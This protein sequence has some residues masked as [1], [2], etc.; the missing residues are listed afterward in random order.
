MAHN[1]GLQS[2]DAVLSINGTPVHDKT[3]DQAIDLMDKS[4]KS[5]NL[6]I[7]R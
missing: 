1:L 5:L 2:G 3:Q 4:G 7:F 6:E